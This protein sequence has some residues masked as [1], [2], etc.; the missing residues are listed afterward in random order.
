MSGS[1][2]VLSFYMQKIRAWQEETAGPPV[3]GFAENVLRETRDSNAVSSTGLSLEKI[4]KP[5]RGDTDLQVC[6][7]ETLRPL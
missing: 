6:R 1:A 5:L 2:D 7:E 4:S 3:D